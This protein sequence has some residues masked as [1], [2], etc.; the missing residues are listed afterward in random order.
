MENLYI[1]YQDDQKRGHLL[2]CKKIFS[3]NDYMHTGI[4]SA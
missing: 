4:T 1:N 2:L 3:D